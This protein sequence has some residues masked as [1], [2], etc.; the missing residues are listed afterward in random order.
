MITVKKAGG[1]YFSILFYI[2][3]GSHQ[4]WTRQADALNG[5]ILL[6]KVKTDEYLDYNSVYGF[7]VVC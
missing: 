3:V 4:K 6:L 7:K 2:V 1:N 5:L